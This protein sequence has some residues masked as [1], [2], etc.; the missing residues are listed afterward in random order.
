MGF[1]DVYTLFSRVISETNKMANPGKVVLKDKEHL[2]AL[3]TYQRGIVINQLHYIDEI[4]T[5]R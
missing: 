4:K 3:H 2:V 5:S 1:K